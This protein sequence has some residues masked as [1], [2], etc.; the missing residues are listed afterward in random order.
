MKALSVVS[1]SGR[2]IASGEKTIEV[3]RWLPDLSPDEDL[4]IIENDKYLTK[5]GDTDPDGRAVAIVRVSLVRP[6]IM[7]D[8]QPACASYF[9]QGWHSWILTNIRPISSAKKVLAARG[10]YE[11][12]AT[13]IFATK[14]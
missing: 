14:T 4:L 13:E 12:D 6:F 2:K 1:P 5:T 9:E 3:R 8:M 7:A 11:V 10:I